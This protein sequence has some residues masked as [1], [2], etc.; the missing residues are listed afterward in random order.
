VTP[1]DE[2][3]RD[4]RNGA[5]VLLAAPILLLAGAHALDLAPRATWLATPAALAGLVMP[6]VAFR[7][8]QSI[9]RTITERAPRRER[10]TAIR[11]ATMRSLGASAAVAA[12][13][14]AAYL[15]TRDLGA[16]AGPALHVAVAGALWPTRARVSRF[17]GEDLD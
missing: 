13:G 6:A 4:L 12:A 15:V 14:A 10:E 1:P 7:M 17:L 8:Y 11:R 3:L 2:V 9:E 5:A 16:C